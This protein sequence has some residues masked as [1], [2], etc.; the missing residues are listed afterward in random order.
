M[1]KVKTEP[2]FWSKFTSVLRATLPSLKPPAVKPQGADFS[3]LAQTHSVEGKNPLSLLSPVKERISA[4]SQ[5]NPYISFKCWLLP[6]LHQFQSVSSWQLQSNICPDLDGPSNW[7][8]CGTVWSD[9][10]SITSQIHQPDLLGTTDSPVGTGGCMSPN[11]HQLPGKQK[12]KITMSLS[13]LGPSPYCP[14][15]I[16]CRLEP[17]IQSRE[18]KKKNNGLCRY[19]R[20][21]SSASTFQHPYIFQKSLWITF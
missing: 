19:Q 5:P 4:P 14:P 2:S 12:K 21:G 10:V 8:G 17:T 16:S 1:L 3:L 11:W 9:L 7:H 15:S 20:P 13:V 6:C 18:R